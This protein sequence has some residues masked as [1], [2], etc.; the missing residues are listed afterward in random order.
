MASEDLEATLS[1]AV[2]I[3]AGHAAT[4]ATWGTAAVQAKQEVDAAKTEIKTTAEYVKGCAEDVE[5]W[6]HEAEDFAGIASDKSEEAWSAVDGEFD[7]EGN[8][9]KAGAKQYAEQAN[10]AR[11]DAE[12][13]KGQAEGFATQASTSATNAST[14]ASNANKSATASATS[15]SQAQ[16]YA[17]EAKASA[18]DTLKRKYWAEGMLYSDNYNGSLAELKVDYKEIQRQFNFTANS[19]VSYTYFQLWGEHK[20]WVLCSM[21]YYHSVFAIL[22]LDAKTV[23]HRIL[24]RKQLAM[25]YTAGGVCLTNT[26]LWQFTITNELFR[27]N[28]ANGDKVSVTLEALGISV[29]DMNCAQCSAGLVPLANGDVLFGAKYIIDKD[30]MKVVG[31]VALEEG[32]TRNLKSQN[33]HTRDYAFVDRNDANSAT[34]SPIYFLFM[35]GMPPLWIDDRWTTDADCKRVVTLRTIKT[36]D[37]S[38]DLG[39]GGPAFGIATAQGLSALVKA[40]SAVVRYMTIDTTQSAPN[41]VKVTAKQ[42]Y[43]HSR[44][45]PSAF[46][47]SKGYTPAADMDA[48]DAPHIV[49]KTGAMFAGYFGVKRGLGTVYSPTV[50]DKA[51]ALP[52]S[53]K[54]QGG[55][56]RGI[57]PGGSSEFFPLFG[58]SRNGTSV[59]ITGGLYGNAN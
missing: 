6:A 52:S 57:H 33:Y 36:D 56:Y 38:I 47:L 27:F 3:S 34:P 39:V 1:N 2:E 49:F 26:D 45:L 22:D 53:N 44:T 21:D 19:Q 51:F 24:N 37:A 30:T 48:K 13:A 41:I 11:D 40:G 18:V 14:S 15:A 8:L 5:S 9:I 12:A 42:S 7:R 59:A 50:Y 10:Q 29:S 20:K 43:T 54:F 55:M 16:G 17:D 35:D 28:L 4:A 31:E 32:V 23:L 25:Y 46:C 58:C